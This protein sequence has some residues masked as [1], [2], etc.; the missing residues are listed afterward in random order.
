MNVPPN[1]AALN[2]TPAGGVPGQQGSGGSGEGMSNEEL[3]EMLM[4]A[5]MNMDQDQLRQIAA[6]A[7][8]RFAGMEPGR[9]VG[10]RSASE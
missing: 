6:M 2:A 8:S 9:P 5:L 1:G 3:A 4:A 10:L 7:V